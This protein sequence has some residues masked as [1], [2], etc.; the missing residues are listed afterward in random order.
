MMGREIVASPSTVIFLALSLTLPQE[1]ASRMRAPER[2]PS[3]SS[4]VV[5]Y[6]Q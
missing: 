6:M 2:E 3:Y 1:T 5:R 4:A